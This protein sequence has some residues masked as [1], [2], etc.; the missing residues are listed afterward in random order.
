MQSLPGVF[1]FHNLSPV[2]WIDTLLDADDWIKLLRL[3][4]LRFLFNI[5]RQRAI[6]VLE[7]SMQCLKYNYFIQKNLVE[8]CMWERREM[9]CERNLWWAPLVL[10]AFDTPFSWFLCVI[11]NSLFFTYTCIFYILSENY[12]NVLDMNMIY[13]ITK[14]LFRIFR[15]IY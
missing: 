10:C 13:V 7:N 5:T 12:Y 15:N 9:E 14:M 3:I 8:N 1:L 6:I 11:W 2:R 4:L